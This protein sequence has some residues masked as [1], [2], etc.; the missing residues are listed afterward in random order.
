MDTKVKDLSRE[1]LKALIQDAVEEALTGLV[2][3]PDRGLELRAKVQ[4]RLQYSL[5]HFEEE[6]RIPAGEVVQGA[7]QTVNSD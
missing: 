6:Q 5:K 4:E 2:G 1:E 7:A 3:D